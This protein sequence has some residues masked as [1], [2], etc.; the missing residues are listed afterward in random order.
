MLK[1]TLLLAAVA[2]GAVT[3]ALSAVSPQDAAKY[4]DY[5]LGFTGRDQIAG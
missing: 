5:V 1:K 4:F 2:L 3:P